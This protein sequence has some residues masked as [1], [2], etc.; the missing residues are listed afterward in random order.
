MKKLFVAVVLLALTFNL[1]AQVIGKMFP[2]M[3]AETV[4]DKKVSLPGDVKGNTRCS[5]WL[6]QR[7]RRTS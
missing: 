4:E 2:D 7:S 1:S 5:G 6:I 3:Q